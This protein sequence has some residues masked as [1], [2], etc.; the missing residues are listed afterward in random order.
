MVWDNGNSAFFM[1]SAALV[2]FM[3]PGVAFFYGGLVSD[4]S[5]LTMMMQSYAAMGIIGLI[6]WFIGFSVCFGSTGY[7]YGN[8]GTFFLLQNLSAGQELSYNGLTISGVSGLTFVLFQLTFAM[9]TPTLMTGAFADR[10]RFGPYLIF[11]TLW[12]FAVY[13]PFCHMAWGGGWFAQWGVWDFA[14]GTVVH[15]TAGWSALGSLAVLGKRPEEDRAEERPHNIPFVVLGAAIL[16]FGW[17]GFNAGSAFAASSSAAVAGLNTQLAAASAL[18][19]WVMLEWVTKGKPSLVGACIGSVVGLVTITPCAGYCQPWA[20]IVVGFLGAV[21]C[22]AAVELRKR[23]LSRYVDDALDVWGCHGVGGFVGAI[24]V[25]ALADP[26]VCNPGLTSGIETPTW[27][28]NP[29]TVS[30]S[31][32]QFGK[33]L[34]AAI[35][36]ALWSLLVTPLILKLLSLIMELKPPADEHIDEHLHGEVAYH[37]PQKPYASNVSS[38]KVGVIAQQLGNDISVQ[39]KPV[40]FLES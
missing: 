20:A 13:T 5:V 40:R 27:C 17:F 16:W 29:N 21:V 23:L 10:M 12:F 25:G 37:S 15:I 6:W 1:I 2:Q 9:I 24:L 30:R 7:V 34:A 39:P 38:V 28:A 33:Q 18:F 31:G 3:T 8:P 26:D 36:C 4:R 35:I 19:F 22:F 11:I 14:G 32:L